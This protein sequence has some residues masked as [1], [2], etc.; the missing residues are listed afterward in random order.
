MENP[1]FKLEKVVHTPANEEM[2]DFEGPLDLILYLLGKN[3]MQ[4]Q[5]ISI[6]TI[7]EQY[8]DWL[9]YRKKWIWTLPASLSQ[10]LRT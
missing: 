1:I 3:R 6:A 5:D 9:D 4:I 7:L 10:W 2:Q 8:L